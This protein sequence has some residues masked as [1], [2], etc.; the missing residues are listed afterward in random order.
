MRGRVGAL[1]VVGFVVGFGLGLSVSACGPATAPAACPETKDCRG[2]RCGPDPVCGLS[3]GDCAC[4]D[5]CVDGACSYRMGQA[6][7]ENCCF[8]NRTCYQGS[9]CCDN[10]LL[11]GNGCCAPSFG[12]FCLPV[13]FGGPFCSRQCTSSNE[14]EP[15]GTCCT[16]LDGG[17]GAC[18]PGASLPC[19]CRTRAECPSG[20]CAPAVN[21]GGAPV[22]PYVCKADDGTAYGGCEAGAAL[23]ATGT[24]CVTDLDSNRFCA[25]ECTTLAECGGAHCNDYDFGQSPCAGPT[26]CGP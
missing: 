13:E 20:A 25:R 9:Y 14:C 21:D 15:T 18:V 1:V 24:C 12:A 5:V 22:G 6:C 11:C 26:A 4:T 16:P 23:C 19:M 8:G 17:S 7:G 2:R 10:A 3:C